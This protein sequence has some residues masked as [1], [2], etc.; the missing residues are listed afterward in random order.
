[1][2]C[3]F[4]AHSESIIPNDIKVENDESKGIVIKEENVTT[5]EDAIAALKTVMNWC[6]TKLE[7][8]DHELLTLNRIKETTLDMI[9]R[10][11]PNSQTCS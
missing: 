1:M 2:E 4:E 3:T 9:N 11:K 5:A 7:Y 10:Q 6:E 8:N